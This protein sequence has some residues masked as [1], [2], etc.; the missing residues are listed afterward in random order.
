M[1]NNE[2]KKSS[3]KNNENTDKKAL[4]ASSADIKL[5]EAIASAFEGKVSSKGTVRIN[6]SALTEHIVFGRGIPFLIENGVARIVVTPGDLSD[7]D[8]TIVIDTINEDQY[9][10]EVRPKVITNNT[11]QIKRWNSVSHIAQISAIATSKAA[12]QASKIME[13]VIY[14]ENDKLIRSSSEGTEVIKNIKTS[15]VNEPRIT[16]RTK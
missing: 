1:K 9:T 16:L 2:A 5:G 13:T 11:G 15:Q 3:E 4:I 7:P 12:E 6:K 10:I 8:G 14:V